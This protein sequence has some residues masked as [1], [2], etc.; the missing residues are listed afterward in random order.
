MIELVIYLLDHGYSWTQ[1][2]ELIEA[3]TGVEGL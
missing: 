2:V 3:T 1:A